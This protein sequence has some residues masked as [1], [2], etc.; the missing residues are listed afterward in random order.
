[1]AGHSKAGKVAFS[2]PRGKT[3]HPAR[4]LQRFRNV[5]GLDDY[6]PQGAKLAND[7]LVVQ[8]E[9]KRQ[10][11]RAQ[12]CLP[13]S[14]A[15]EAFRAASSGSASVSAWGGCEMSRWA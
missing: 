15:K 1:V 11:L 7:P 12:R 5:T 4:L 10:Q 9:R 3:A 14:C 6:L 8:Q 13:W 2:E